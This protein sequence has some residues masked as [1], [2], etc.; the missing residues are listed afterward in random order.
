MHTYT[1]ETFH[2]WHREVLAVLAANAAVVADEL[3]LQ[4]DFELGLTPQEVY[5]WH[6]REP[7]LP[8]EDVYLD[9]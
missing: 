5:L 9:A 6:V 8:D 7:E 3:P 4:D 1:A 2:D